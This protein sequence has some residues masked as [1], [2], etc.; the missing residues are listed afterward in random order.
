MKC[1][2]NGLCVCLAFIML[3]LGAIGIV[4]PIVPSTPFLLLATLLF[5]KGSKRFHRWFLSTKLYQNH[6]QHVVKD[7]AMTYRAKMTTLGMLSVVFTI[8]IL[9]CPVWYGRVF[10]IGVALGHIYYFLFRIKTITRSV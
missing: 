2:I 4:L 1:I 6:I 10:I 9:F 8:G 7:K 5:A 3:G